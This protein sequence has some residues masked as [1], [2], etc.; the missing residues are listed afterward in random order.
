[1]LE[2]TFAQMAELRRL[3]AVPGGEPDPT[4]DDVLCLLE[5]SRS[6]LKG[7]AYLPRL[8]SPATRALASGDVLAHWSNDRSVGAA[9]APAGGA[10]RP[11]DHTQVGPPRSDP[12]GSCRS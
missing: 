7:S 2:L 1:M 9:G 8:N 4:A 5:V 3:L 12:T 11:A 6:C 10:W